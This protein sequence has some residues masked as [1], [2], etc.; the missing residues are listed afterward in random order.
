MAVRRG[1]RDSRFSPAKVSCES[2]GLVVV[3]TLGIRSWTSGSMVE[4]PI[5]RVS[6]RPR[7]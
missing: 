4:E 2:R 1:S 7:T 6:S 5:S 3:W